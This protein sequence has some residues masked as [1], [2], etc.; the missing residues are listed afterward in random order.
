M[1]VVITYLA[2]DNA[3][4]R[5]RARRAAK[6]EQMEA[7]ARLARKI[8]VASTG[9]SLTVSRAINS[10]S[11]RSKHDTGS[12]CLPEVALYQAG[13]RNVRKDATHIVK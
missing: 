11:L 1:T 5:Y 10:H 4:A 8:A 7:D 2:K 12:A 3:K 6:R 13:H 9:C